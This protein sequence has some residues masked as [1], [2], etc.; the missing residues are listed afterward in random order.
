MNYFEHLPVINYN[1]NLCRNIKTVVTL[2]DDSSLLDYK[3]PDYLN[4]TDIISKKY[5]DSYSYDWLVKL[6]NKVVDPYY[7]LGVPNDD[8]EAFL[9]AK[10]GSLALADKRIHHFENNYSNDDSMLEVS[11]YNAMD[12][13]V[14]KYWKPVY[15]AGGDPIRYVRRDEDWTVDTNIIL[16]LVVESHEYQVGDLCTQNITAAYGE[17]L[18]VTETEIWLG[19]VIG[20][21]N[22]VDSLDKATA[23]E[24]ANIIQRNIPEAEEHYWDPV[25]CYEYEDRLNDS[26]RD[27][28][29]LDNRLKGQAMDKLKDLY[30]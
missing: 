9:K 10:Y 12:S 16:Y 27:I 30:E 14:R 6:S 19:K 13:D 15:N 1:G 29:L 22:Q 20:N 7:D 3:L 17:V 23:L 2:G 25:T 26:K 21:F 8:F 5:Y 28:K 18:S 4:R 11:T 24:S